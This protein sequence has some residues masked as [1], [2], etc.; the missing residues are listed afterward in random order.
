M[1]KTIIFLC[2]EMSNWVN[3]A[4]LIHVIP[5]LYCYTCRIC[6]LTSVMQFPNVIHSLHT[7]SHKNVNFSGTSHGKVHTISS[8]SPAPIKYI[9]HN[10]LALQ[11]CY[12][13]KYNCINNNT[14]TITHNIVIIIVL[15]I[16]IFL[17]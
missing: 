3:G 9:H 13:K 16:V 14:C 7:Y 17:I 12:R 15:Y 10:Y 11:G 4:Y 6:V 1:Y 8:S 2:Q 5:R